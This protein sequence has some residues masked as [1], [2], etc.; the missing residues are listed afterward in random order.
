MLKNTFTALILFFSLATSAKEVK[1][2]VHGMVCS[3][4][5]QGIKK[6]FSPEAAV[7]AVHVNLAQQLVTLTLKE[8]QTISDERIKEL[9]LDAGFEVEKIESK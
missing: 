7:E 2:T 1:V 3:F 6:K 4:C 5:T 9:I 8:N